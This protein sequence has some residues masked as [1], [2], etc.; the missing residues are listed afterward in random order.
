MCGLSLFFLLNLHSNAPAKYNI[1]SC[2]DTI[3]H[4]MHTLTQLTPLNMK[5][6]SK[7]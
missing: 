3:M 1:D 5:V 2:T 6:A 7:F 4:S